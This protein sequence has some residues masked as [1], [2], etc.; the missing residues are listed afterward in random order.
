MLP[1]PFLSPPESFI[2]AN[3]FCLIFPPTSGH[4]RHTITSHAH[5]IRIWS[6]PAGTLHKD[7]SDDDGRPMG[8]CGQNWWFSKTDSLLR[9]GDVWGKGGAAQTGKKSLGNR[10]RGGRDWQTVANWKR[11]VGRWMNKKKGK[12]EKL[13]LVNINTHTRWAGTRVLEI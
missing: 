8:I 11:I 4:Q 2:G 9:W 12:E 10:W 3:R 6:C 1:L 5:L 13:S 7:D